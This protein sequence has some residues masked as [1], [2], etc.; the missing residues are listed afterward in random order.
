MIF[1]REETVWIFD[2]PYFGSTNRSEIRMDTASDHT[3]SV[4]G[5]GFV[6]DGTDRTHT[7]ADLFFS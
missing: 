6:V 2:G 1:V 3:G 5:A 4:V 7:V